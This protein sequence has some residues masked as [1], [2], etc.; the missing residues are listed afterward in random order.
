MTDFFVGTSGWSYDEWKGII[1]PKNFPNSKMFRYYQEFFYS[2]EINSTFYQIPSRKTVQNW[3]DSS[4]PNFRFSA[5]IPELVTHKGKLN[6]DKVTS[7]IS[8]YITKTDLKCI[9]I[10]GE[11]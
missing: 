2:S 8:E 7:P 6:L 11:E 5:K 4:D 3:A 1:Y 10:R 9:E